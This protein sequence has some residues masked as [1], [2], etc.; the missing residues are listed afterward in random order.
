MFRECFFEY[1][2]KYSGEYNLIMSY[3]TDTNDEFDTG[4]KYEVKID[5]RPTVAESVLYSVDYSEEQLEFSVEISNIDEAIPFEQMIEV[6][7]WLFA[8]QGWQRLRIESPDYQDYYLM[9]LLIPEKDIADG[10]GYRA[11]KCT[12]KSISGFW[13]RDIASQI[14]TRTDMEGHIGG[15]GNFSFQM[16]IKTDP[17]LPIYPIVDCKLNTSSVQGLPV[18]ATI[19]F[20]IKNR[21]NGSVLSMRLSTSDI[22]ILNADRLS[23]DS[24]YPFFY[25]GDKTNYKM[26]YAPMLENINSGL[27]YLNN[28]SNEIQVACHI[29]GDNSAPVYYDY[30]QIR[31]VA[32]VRIG[33]F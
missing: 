17:A 28:G 27:L 32:K 33:G 8:Q 30:L 23:I 16:D 18:D 21:T 22:G 2:G 25:K 1:A 5:T 11:I 31:C 19:P 3:I 6:K 15:N 12:V 7:E 24:Q 29:T 26:S 9:C 4:G 20:W 14:F 13:Y 10:T